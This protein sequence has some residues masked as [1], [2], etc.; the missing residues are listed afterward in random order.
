MDPYP[1]AK[2]ILQ[3]SKTL[4]FPVVEHKNDPQH[5]LNSHDYFVQTPEKMKKSFWQ[6]IQCV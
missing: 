6:E 3:E 1:S 5:L 2:G 4:E